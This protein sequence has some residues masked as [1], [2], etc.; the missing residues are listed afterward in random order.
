ML[1]QALSFIAFPHPNAAMQR[2]LV[3][4]FHEAEYQTA[5]VQEGAR[6]YLCFT[7]KPF[8]HGETL[9]SLL[10]ILRRPIEIDNEK[11]KSNFMI[12]FHPILFHVSATN[13][14][15]VSHIHI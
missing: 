5:V 2:R 13:C 1:L 10:L 15:L 9:G 3:N 4:P 7:I 12:S 11:S 8:I 14:K 6:N